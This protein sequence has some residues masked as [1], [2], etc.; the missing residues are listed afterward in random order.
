MPEL[1]EVTTTARGLQKVLPGLTITDIW[2]DLAKKTPSRKHFEETL[3][4]EAFYK[5][6]KKE[7]VGAKVVS[8]D[9]R[10]KNILIHLLG[11]HTILIHLKMTG[12]ILYG[13]Y[14]YDKK[15]NTWTPAVGQPTA[16]FDP[17]NRFIHVVFS[18]SNGKH[19]V[20]CDSRKFGKVTLLETANKDETV[21]LKGIGP[22]PL[23]KSFT[24]ERF[25]ERI[26]K[27]PTG[28]IKTV[29]MDQSIIAGIGNIY[30]DEML[31]MAGIH[32][33]SHSKAVPTPRLKILYD[34]MKEVLNKGIDF[35]GDS[36]SDYRDING[37]PGQFQGQHNVYRRTKQP[38]GKKGCKG[39]ILRKVINGRSAHFCSVHQTLFI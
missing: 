3:K 30:S 16:L 7:V 33:Q 11:G 35:G 36:T 25:K 17:F 21:H 2:T 10:A 15:K 29:L 24:F 8:V 13:V 20:L 23:D 19:F 27:Q 38:C 31:W 39:V 1:P 4:S 28:N 18:L 22:E 34:S 32:P 26:L 5:K 14:T 6:F 37:K 12:H 9:R